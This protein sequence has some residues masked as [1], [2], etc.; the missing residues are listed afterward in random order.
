[1]LRGIQRALNHL[2]GDHPHI[3]NPKAYL[4]H[5]RRIHIET[6]RYTQFAL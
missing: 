4:R 3:L 6:K 5:K 1:M 2:Q